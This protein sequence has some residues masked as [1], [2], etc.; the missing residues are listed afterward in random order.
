MRSRP[1][2]VA[3]LFYPAEPQVLQRRLEAWLP[4]DA[5]GGPRPKAL[6]VPHAGYD[7]S[8]AIAARAYARLGPLRGTIERVV[9]AGPAHRVYVRGAAIPSVAAFESP[10]GPVRLDAAALARLAALDFVDVDDV[11]H[12]R[13]HCLEVHLPLLQR[14][15]GDFAL[16]PIV[17]GDATPAEAERLFEALWG[18]DETLLV[19][20]TDLSHYL[21]YDEASRRDRATA[22][23]ILRLD[24]RLDPEDAC[25]AHPLNGF[26]LAA[27]H[28]GLNAELV[29]LRNSGD[30]AGD[31]DRVVGYGAFAF[32]A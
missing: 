26:L 30:T 23:A 31:R 27:R 6:V 1:A 29:D 9:L 16:V 14:A 12:A 5:E 22:E 8:G 25:G 28:H 15:L 32:H 18:G 3:G 2:A 19:V 24:A 7:Y 21:P 20:S 17:V 4:A 10:L 13:E 11:P